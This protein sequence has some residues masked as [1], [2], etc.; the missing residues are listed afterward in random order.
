VFSGGGEIELDVEC[1]DVTLIDLTRPWRARG[2]P[3]HDAT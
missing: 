1:V 3:A 2:R